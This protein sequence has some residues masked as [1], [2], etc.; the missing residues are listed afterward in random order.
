MYLFVN[1]PGPDIVKFL[2]TINGQQHILIGR[3]SYD[4]VFGIIYE[5]CKHGI[6]EDQKCEQVN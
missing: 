5:K 4:I 3:M 2:V 1:N 6:H